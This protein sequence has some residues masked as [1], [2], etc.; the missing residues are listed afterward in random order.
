MV[1][2]SLEVHLR[3]DGCR[4]LKEKRRVLR[5]LIDRLRRDLHLSVAE[6][7]DHDLWNVAV[8]GVACVGVDRVSVEQSLTLALNTIDACGDVRVDSVVRD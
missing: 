8:V 4:S 7:G 5:S 2:G 1:V 3:M 6:V